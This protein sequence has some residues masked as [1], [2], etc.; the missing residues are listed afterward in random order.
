[1]FTLF[2]WCITNGFLFH[3]NPNIMSEETKMIIAVVCVASDLNLI[4]VWCGGKHI[5]GKDNNG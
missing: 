3:Y 2:I 4:S 1:M 5:S